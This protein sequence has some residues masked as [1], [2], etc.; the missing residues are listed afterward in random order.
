MNHTARYPEDDEG[1]QLQRLDD[2]QVGGRGRPLRGG[3][4]G[5]GGGAGDAAKGAYT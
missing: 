5:R 1:V 3:R 2:G 4:G